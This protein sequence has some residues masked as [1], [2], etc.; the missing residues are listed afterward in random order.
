LIFVSGEPGYVRTVGPNLW[1]G[2]IKDQK[3][4]IKIKAL[5]TPSMRLVTLLIALAAGV[6]EGQQPSINFDTIGPKAGETVPDF[7]LR[8]QHGTSRR[9]SSLIGPKGTMLVFYR[10]ADW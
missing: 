6:V 3:S 9:L 8:D 4:K 5:Y 7:E 1:F 2:Q 10:S